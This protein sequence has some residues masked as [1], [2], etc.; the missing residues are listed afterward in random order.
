MNVL[1]P[2]QKTQKKIPIVFVGEINSN[3]NAITNIYITENV[4]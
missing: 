3:E 1:K 2:K 4:Y